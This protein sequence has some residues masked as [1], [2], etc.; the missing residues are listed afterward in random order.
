MPVTTNEKLKPIIKVMSKILDDSDGIYGI[1]NIDDPNTKEVYQ[2][3]D[4]KETI[5]ESDD[6]EVV[7]CWSWEY[8]D[9]YGLTPLEFAELESWYNSKVEEVRK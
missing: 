4:C 6:I 7:Y 3:A 2:D 8:F 1:F 9:V 5:Y